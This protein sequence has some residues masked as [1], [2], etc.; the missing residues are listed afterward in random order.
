MIKII[1]TRLSIK[2]IDKLV[3]HQARIIEIESWDE[4]INEIKEGKSIFRHGSMHG[5]TISPKSTMENLIFDDFHL[6]CD[7]INFVGMKSKLLAYML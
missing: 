3:D 1:E 5:E 6:S 2:D 7:I 4:Y